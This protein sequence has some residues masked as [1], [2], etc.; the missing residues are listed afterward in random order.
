MN[1]HDKTPDANDQPMDD[2]QEHPT[3]DTPADPRRIRSAASIRK[4]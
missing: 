1:E 4:R 3:I 2:P